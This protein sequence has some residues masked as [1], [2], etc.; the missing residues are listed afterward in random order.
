MGAK[1]RIWLFAVV[2]AMALALVAPPALAEEKQPPEDKVAVVNGKVITQMDFRREVSRLQ[3]QLISMRKPLG[4][5]QLSEI[6]KQA[7]ENLINRELL[8]QESQKAGTRV[9]EAAIDERIKGLKERFPSE[10]E[11]KNALSR[12]NL[13]EEALRSQ[14]ERAMAIQ[15]F[16]DERFVQKVTVSEE[17][18]KKYYDAN[19]DLFKEPERVRVSHILIIVDPEAGES[20]KAEARKKIEEIQQKV[21]E[22]GDFAALAEEFSQ[23]PSRVRG[24]DI[25]YFRRGRGDVVKAFED[26]ALALEPGEVS[27]IVETSYGFH[28]IKLIEKIPETTIPYEVIKDRLKQYLKGQKVNEEVNLYVE[29]LKEKAKVE[30]FLKEGE[31]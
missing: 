11:F 10:A 19:P 2:A 16:V 22:G 8:Y 31:Q 18:V 5:F 15:K 7:L 4:A 12:M 25:G 26:A 3:Q 27:D 1:G 20:Q 14:L 21:K 24:G 9:E 13:T 6:R 28:L 30:R 29:K 17:E 23:G